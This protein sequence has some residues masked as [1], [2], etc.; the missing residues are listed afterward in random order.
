MKPTFIHAIRKAAGI[1][2]IATALV[3]GPQPAQ[4]L[5]AEAVAK[6]LQ[7]WPVLKGLKLQNLKAED[8]HFTV[9][10]GTKKLPALVFDTGTDKKPV[11]NVAVYPKTLDFGKLYRKG[12]GEALGGLSLSNPAMVVAQA[13]SSVKLSDL[14]KPVQ[15]G[16][17]K[18]FGTRVK[19]VTY[20]E[21]V[22]FSATL[23]LSRSDLLKELKPALG[24]ADT[25]AAM[26]GTLGADVL[27]YLAN[28]SAKSE[29]DDLAG[30]S[31]AAQ[32]KGLKPKEASRSFTSPSL[33]VVYRADKSGTVTPA[34]YATVTTEVDKDKWT[35]KAALGFDPKATNADTRRIA[36]RGTYAE[37]ISKSIAIGAY[38]AAALGLDAAVMGNGKLAVAFTGAD[39]K[40]QPFRVN[41]RLDRGRILLEQTFAANS[42]VKDIIG[43]SQQALDKVPFKNPKKVGDVITGTV[44]LAG[45]DMEAFVFKP[46]PKAKHP[47]LALIPKAFDFGSWLPAVKGS[48]LD[49]AKVDKAA[50]LVVAS[51]G[52]GDQALND[53]PKLVADKLSGVVDKDTIRANKNKLPIA[54]GVNLYTSVDVKKS[55]ALGFMLDKLGI[56]DRALTL[57]GSVN[58]VVFWVLPEKVGAQLKQD[59]KIHEEI[60][61]TLRIATTISK[62]QIPGL[63][64][65]FEFSPGV[66]RFRGDAAYDRMA[67]GTDT[68]AVEVAAEIVNAVKVKLPGKTIT[69]N[70]QLN[71]H[72]GIADKSFEVKLIGT[73]TYDWQKA[74]GVPFLTLNDISLAATLN[75]DKAGKLTFVAGLGSKT[76]LGAQTVESSIDLVFEKG[77]FEDLVLSVPGKVELAKLPGLSKIPGVKEFVFEDLTV[78]KAATQGKLT[79]KTLGTKAEAA[80]VN[81]DNKYTLFARVRDLGLKTLLKGLPK[82]INLVGELKMPR[83]VLAFSAQKLTGYELAN[84]P[85][86]AQAMLA[87][88]ITNPSNEVP[89]WDGVTLIGAVGEKDLPKPLHKIIADDL[90]VYKVIDGDLVLAGGINGI[91]GG[92][93]RVGLYADLPGFKFPQG[94]PWS[95]VVSLERAKAN[96]FIRADVAATMLNLGVGGDMQVKIPHLDDPKKI[97]TIKFR[98]EAYASVDLVSVAGGVKVVGR[99]DGKWREPLGLKNFAFENPAVLIGADS[100]GSVEFGFGGTTEFAARNN[101]TLRFAGDFITNIN[102]SSTIPLPKKLG[103]RL[104]AKKLSGVG[105]MEIADALFRGVMTGPMASLVV[106]A[107]PDPATKKTAQYLQAELKKRSLLD[108]L[109]VEKLPLPYLELT[110]VDLFFATPGAVIPGREDTLEG[111]GLVVAG[112]AYLGLMGQRTQLAETDNR[113]T[114]KDGLKI[115]SKLPPRNLGPLKLRAAEIDIAANIQSLPHFKIKADASLLGAS[116][117][118]DIE[119]SNDKIGFFYDKNL[120]PVLKLRVDAKT[121]GKDLFRVKDFTVTAQSKNSIDEIIT[122]KV[123]PLLGIPKAVSEVIKKSTPL[124][125][126]GVAFEGS[127]TNFIKG[128]AVTLKLDHKYFGQRMDPALIELKP[129]WKDPESALPATKIADGLRRSFLL[130]LASNPVNLPP[131][132]LGLLKLTGAKLTAIP[133]D[134]K[135]PKFVVSGGTDFLGAK[136]NVNV[137][138]SDAGYA[139]E[140]KDR[141]ANIWQADMKVRSIGGTARRPDDIA[142]YGKITN[143]FGPW[144]QKEVGGVLKSGSSA[145]SGRFRTAQDGLSSAI[146]EVEKIDSRIRDARAEARENL[147]L[148]AKP[149]EAAES[150]LRS[151][152][153]VMDRARSVK[154]RLRHIARHCCNSWWKYV[155]RKIAQRVADA[156]EWAFERAE[157]ARNHTR[158]LLADLRRDLERRRAR[159]NVDWHPKVAFWIVAREV[160]LKALT[161]ARLTMAGA[162]HLSNT[163]GDV[164]QKLLRAAAGG[165]VL[166]VKKV[167]IS[168]KLKELK[169]EFHMLADV[170]GAKD[171]YMPIKVNLSNPADS[172]LRFL[173]NTFG[174]VIRGEGV[175][176]LK[177]NMPAPP[178]LPVETVSQAEI[179][180]SVVAAIREKARLAAE[181]NA[182]SAKS[183]LFA[184]AVIVGHQ[185][186]CVDFSESTKNKRGARRAQMY[187]CRGNKN[188]RFTMTGLGELR[189]DGLCMDPQEDSWLWGYKCT[190]HEGMRFRLLADGR[191]QH[192][193]SGRCVDLWGVESGN[194]KPLRLGD[195]HNGANQKWKV[196]TS[197]PK[198]QKIDGFENSV[199]VGH[200]GRCVDFSE[201]T[202]NKRGARRAQMYDCR[203]NKNQRFTM[204][205]L[206]E[207]RADGLC[208]DP[209]EDSWLWGYKC[210]GH[211]GMRFRQLADGRIQHITSGLCIDLWGVESGNGKPLRLGGCHNGANQK[212]RVTKNVPKPEAPDQ[213]FRNLYV[214][215][216]NNAA[217]LDSYPQGGALGAIPCRAHPNLRFTFWSDGTVRHDPQDRCINVQR[218]A[219][220]GAPVVVAK[221]DGHS[222]QKWSIAWSGGNG[223]SR[224]DATW[225]FRIV[226]EASGR[227]LTMR[228]GH[229]YTIDCG[230]SSNSD[231]WPADQTWRASKTPLKPQSREANSFNLAQLVNGS[232]LCADEES[233]KLSSGGKV[234]T[235]S[236]NSS[237]PSRQRQLWAHNARGQ[238]VATNGLCLD[239]ASGSTRPAR[240]DQLIIWS[241]NSS[242]DALARQRWRRL[243]DGR[244]QHITGGQCIDVTNNGGS[245]GRLVVNSCSGDKT[246]KWSIRGAS[247]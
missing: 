184:N 224:V 84:L 233:G 208:M 12:G 203:G 155:A 147:K 55:N 135:D 57:V 71:L 81:I 70:S 88:I 77:K 242:G 151:A 164:T 166:N 111:M 21:G 78:S 68:G 37:K 42:T 183:T 91:F 106:K 8:K 230:G 89:I 218:S 6:A 63:K 11:L 25:S 154:D 178:E 190:G 182:K 175:T 188:Q 198:P 130:F 137:V 95:R 199:I 51:G 140:L 19:N 211:E 107:L 75:Q 194:G 214:A 142:Y 150:A 160:A 232:G 80:I 105:Q 195:C 129:V 185:G 62:P 139:F 94:Q 118:L 176:R 127:L 35:F 132:D 171:L 172:D 202:K 16:I 34:A 210:T 122:D 143:G 169:T 72:K 112:K 196:T 209:Q 9:Q 110:D 59:K 226:H 52:G 216:N 245:K 18:I 204:N 56:N 47:Y 23:S 53:L 189:A 123:F 108:I 186:R 206:G 54:D 157:R 36:I 85:K 163:F 32:L 66:L 83:A 3:T 162:E 76:K 158:N 222:D 90:G 20:P 50:L 5:D 2:A 114:F 146:R 213:T 10:L 237:G 73:S 173:A 119:V 43:Y 243:P 156:A 165:D 109:Q 225:R 79:W 144:V 115:Y 64:E 126:D 167:V 74:F 98:G 15:A 99:I 26:A 60:L 223:P 168:G 217:C 4:A 244:I 41:A 201:S 44:T 231:S 148:L 149:I 17:T 61:K 141:L 145:I 121:V 177:N 191:I 113:L 180:A 221:C 131:V 86:A 229:T 212:W 192:I 97:D 30:I 170:L 92:N 102:F 31:L 240:L 138:L 58:P 24:V 161:A 40:K 200:Q 104:Q 29:P 133:T 1:A 179:S 187:D 220:N 67:A 153:W 205:G 236:C 246:Q 152:Q 96:F 100:E 82:P 49:S 159:A 136:R 13:Q 128:G 101:Q 215:A 27:H 39:A 87:D 69:M 48:L 28:G 228:S 193:S 14:P 238:I 22:N 65:V 207:L 45:G 241:C 219:A 93:P 33:T 239:V 174:A 181:R 46:D 235:W 38:E 247:S 227:C 120:G 197:V 134:P 7:Q 103:V 234:I 124:L 117:K 116:E 125:I